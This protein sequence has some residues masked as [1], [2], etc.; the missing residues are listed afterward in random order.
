MFTFRIFSPML[1]FPVE[2]MELL[3][4]DHRYPKEAYVFVFETLDFAQNTLNLGR[5][6]L[7]EP[8]PEEPA[9]PEANAETEEEQSQRHITGQDL[10]VAARQYAI[11]QYGALARAVLSSLGINSTSDI[12][13]IV[14]NMIRIGRM[15]KTADDRRED[16]NDVYDFET[17]FKENYHIGKA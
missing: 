13:E 16:F 9:L 14:Y 10:C 2:F 7:S 4:Q 3:R 8:L 12:G 17:A 5:D 1:S 11:D 15:R 6:T